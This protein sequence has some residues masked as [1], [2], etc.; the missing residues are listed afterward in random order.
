M[1]A[2]YHNVV[3]SPEIDSRDNMI[4]PRITVFDPE[5]GRID[6]RCEAVSGDRSYVWTRR[7]EITQDTMTVTDHAESDSDLTLRSRL[8]IG[9]HDMERSDP[10]KV[11]FLSDDVLITLS[12]DLPFDTL[13][14]PVM[15]DDNGIDYASVIQSETK[16][17]KFDNRIVIRFD[18]R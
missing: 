10:H 4:D 2:S 16:S 1:T 6:M 13:L 11:R 18:R 15:N 7:L 9:R 12:S 5:S 14:L 3:Y 8:F 17:G